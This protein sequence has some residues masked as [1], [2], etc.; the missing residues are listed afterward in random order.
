MNLENHYYDDIDENSGERDILITNGRPFGIEE[1][2]SS[3]TMLEITDIMPG[4]YNTRH[5]R[6]KDVQNSYRRISLHI[7]SSLHSRAK[8]AAIEDDET[9]N[10]LIIG[11]LH[12][13]VDN[14]DKEREKRNRK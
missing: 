4:I 3:D 14:R 13:F 11:L 6:S 5:N 1:G 12:Q 7:S 8:R 9:L 2:E 10:S